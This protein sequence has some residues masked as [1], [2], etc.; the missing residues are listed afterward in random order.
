MG[1]Q[2]LPLEGTFPPLSA[3]PGGHAEPWGHRPAVPYLRGRV[4]RVSGQ[5]QDFAAAPR[6]VPVRVGQAQ[7]GCCPQ[8]ARSRAI[9]LGAPQAVPGSC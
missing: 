6:C 5:G 2:S 7:G 8:P 4:A 3:A 1:L 9:T